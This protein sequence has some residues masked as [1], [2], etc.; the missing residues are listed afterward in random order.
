MIAKAARTTRGLRDTPP[1]TAE[2]LLVDWLC[3]VIAV[4]ATHGEAYGT[5]EITRAGEFFAEGILRGEPIE[6]VKH[7]LRFDVKAATYHD[8]S[9]DQTTEEMRARVVFDL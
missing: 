8:L 6:P 2:D 5:V 4:G 1:P 3:E 7:D 9:L